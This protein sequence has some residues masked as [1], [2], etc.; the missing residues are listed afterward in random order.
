MNDRSAT[1]RSTGPPMASGVR[2]RTLVRSKTRTRSSLLTATRFDPSG[3]NASPLMCFVPGLIC[4]TVFPSATDSTPSTGPK[5][6]AM[7]EPS[8]LNA[9]IPGW[10]YL[11][12]MC[13]SPTSSPLV[14]SNR[15][16]WD[17]W[18]RPLGL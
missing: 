10:S 9:S 6:P 4:A 1:V 14:R 5:F 17:S 16:M 8:G 13:R 2:V 7:T 11:N 12:A 3:V 15:N 18:Q